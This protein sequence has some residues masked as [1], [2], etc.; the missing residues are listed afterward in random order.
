VAFTIANP[1]PISSEL[2]VGGSFEVSRFDTTVGDT[3]MAIHVIPEALKS[4][5][6][7]LNDEQ[8]SGTIPLP[9]VDLITLYE[10]GPPEIALVAPHVQS[11]AD[12]PVLL[13]GPDHVFVN[14]QRMNHGDRVALEGLLATLHAIAEQIGVSGCLRFISHAGGLDYDFTGENTISL[15]SLPTETWLTAWALLR[16]VAAVSFGYHE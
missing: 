13:Q 3:H 8:Q 10:S 11:Y 6:L 1:T 7:L 4:W 2:Y 12:Y 5:K 15:S 16:S 9:A 14:V